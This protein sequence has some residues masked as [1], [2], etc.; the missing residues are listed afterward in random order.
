MALLLTL[1]LGPQVNFKYL[2]LVF[3]PCGN[4][5]V[6]GTQYRPSSRHLRSA[7]S[8]AVQLGTCSSH[9]GIQCIVIRKYYGHWH[10]MPT[11]KPAF[12]AGTFADSAARHVFKP[13]WRSMHY[14]TEIPRSL[15]FNTDPPAIE[16]LRVH[17]GLPAFKAVHPRAHFRLEWRCS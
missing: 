12:K 16:Q 4:N 10:S 17:S 2:I 6:T 13:F 3:N 1:L 8:L 15:A 7:R 9:F 14:Y 5:T 11:F